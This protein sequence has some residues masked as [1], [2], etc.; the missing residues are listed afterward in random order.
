MWMLGVKTADVT[1]CSHA[2]E[3]A[4]FLFIKQHAMPLTPLL[5]GVGRAEEMLDMGIVWH[6]GEGADPGG[7]RRL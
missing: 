2:A 4:P 7:Q 1:M 3:L 6:A 5:P